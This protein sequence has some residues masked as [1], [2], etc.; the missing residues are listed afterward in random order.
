MSSEKSL[1][2]KFNRLSPFGY[3]IIY[4]C[5]NCGR[6]FPM[7]DSDFNYC[8]S[9]GKKIDWGVIYTVNEEW[10]REYLKLKG[11]DLNI[12]GESQA[13]AE[14]LQKMINEIDDYNKCITDGLKRE[15]PKTEATRRAILKVN[16]RY[17]L[18]NGWTIEEL[19]KKGFFTEDDLKLLDEED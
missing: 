13:D 15:M 12:N 14:K 10:K 19:I 4:M 16:I 11:I 17:Y 7:V 3:D 8:P 2:P 1:K 9:C 6:E 18:G 5:G